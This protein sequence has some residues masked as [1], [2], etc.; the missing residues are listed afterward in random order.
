MIYDYL[1]LNIINDSI[2]IL[3]GNF[4]TT[5]KQLIYNIEKNLII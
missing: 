2:L 4:L 3:S 1:D 5:T